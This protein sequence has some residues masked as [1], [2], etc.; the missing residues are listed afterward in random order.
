MNYWKERSWG[1]VLCF[2][3]GILSHLLGKSFPIIG[4]AVFAI[5][6]GMIVGPYFSTR[7]KFQPGIKYT[8]KKILQYAV[9]LLQP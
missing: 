1:L 8:S 9:I 6:L 5:L 7:E 2:L 3:I 4:G